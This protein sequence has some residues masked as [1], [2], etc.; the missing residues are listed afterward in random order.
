MSFRMVKKRRAGD[1]SV[2]HT[3]SE[4]VRCEFDGALVVA[5]CTGTN[6][7]RALEKRGFVL[8]QE[9]PKK[10]K[11]KPKPKPKPKRARDED[12]QFKGDDP[13]TPD[14]DEA[15]KPPKKKSAKKPTK[16]K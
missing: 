14:V 5:N 13:S 15:W 12:G 3:A 16:K 10:A 7:R 11:E 9:P 2:V 1:K 4:I 6:A 8:V